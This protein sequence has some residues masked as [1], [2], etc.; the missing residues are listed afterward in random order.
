MTRCEMRI[1]GNYTSVACSRNAV[2]RVA[3]MECGKTVKMNLCRQHIKMC[4]RDGV[5]ADAN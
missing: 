4:E 1:P 5:L 2:N 3:V